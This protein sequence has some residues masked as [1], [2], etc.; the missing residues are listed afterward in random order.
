MVDAGIL[1]GDIVIARRAPDGEHGD[2]VVA[3]IGD[4]ATVKR[5]YRQG[6]SVRLVAANTAYEP[7]PVDGDTEILGI[8]VGLM[9]EIGRQRVHA[10]IS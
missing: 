6:C 10:R 3:R 1:P 9:R 8:V 4:G 2:V 5:L 7:I